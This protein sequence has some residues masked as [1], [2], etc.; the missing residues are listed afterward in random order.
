MVA[1][2]SGIVTLCLTIGA[3]AFHLS[4]SVPDVNRSECESFEVY[5]LSDH[6]CYIPQG[7]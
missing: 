3:V 6:A 4:S 1:T 2:I 7:E 5:R